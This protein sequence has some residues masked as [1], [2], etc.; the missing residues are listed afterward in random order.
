MKKNI[1]RVVIIIDDLGKCVCATSDP[2]AK[3][4]AKKAGLK[5]QEIPWIEYVLESNQVSE[6]EKDT[7]VPNKKKLKALRKNKGEV[8]DEKISDDQ[9]KIDD[10]TL[11]I[12]AESKLKIVRWRDLLLHSE[13]QIIAI[14]GIGKQRLDHIRV[15]LQSKVQ[16]PVGAA[17]KRKK[18][19]IARHIELN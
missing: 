10:R 5:T 2:D 8:L 14:E 3:K 12:L 13:R 4:I 9:Q 16:L 18:M 17:T 15:T 11:T 6:A 1:Q 19:K 7:I